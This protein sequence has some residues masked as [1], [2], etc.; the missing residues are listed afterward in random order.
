MYVFQLRNPTPFTIPVRVL[1]S[2]PGFPKVCNT[3]GIGGVPIPIPYPDLQ[4][5]LQ[6]RLPN[7]QWSSEMKLPWKS[8]VIVLPKL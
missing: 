1:G 6:I 8:G 4:M 5:R 3:P 2:G 7:G